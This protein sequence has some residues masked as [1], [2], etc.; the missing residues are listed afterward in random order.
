MFTMY[1]HNSFIVHIYEILRNKE[2]FLNCFVCVVPAE[3]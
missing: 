2:T 1:D 3:A